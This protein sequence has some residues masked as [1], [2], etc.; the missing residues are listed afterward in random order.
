VTT[1]SA[2]ELIGSAAGSC[3][4]S[5]FT[6]ASGA[7]NGVKLAAANGQWACS[8]LTYNAGTTYADFDFSSFAPS[9]ATAPLSTGALTANA[10]VKII[11]RNVT[12]PATAGNYPLIHY[13]GTDPTAG[14][15]SLLTS[16][17]TVTNAVGGGV[18]V[19]STGKNVSVS[20]AL[21]V[22]N[23]AFTIAPHISQRITLSDIQAA[24]LSSSNG[25]P[26]YSITG[27]S[28]TSAQ[29]GAVIYNASNVQYTYPSSGS[30]AS[31]SFSYTVTDGTVSATGTVSLTFVKQAGQSGT[32]SVSGGTAT[33]T[34][35]GIPGVQY[36]AQRSSDLMNWMTL[37]VPPLN[38]TP[39]FAAASDGKVSFTDTNAPG[40]SAYY[41]TIQH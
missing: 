23:L 19:D 5:A 33:V 16:L 2:G 37:G 20:V 6:V 39:P 7:T 28:S 17:P 21:G 14:N 32:I 35:Y 30:P 4:S 12:Y 8:G 40:T 27:A 1:V 26:S 38:A 34:L 9:S 36:D 3:A 41:R 15:F 13:T 24:G 31:D 29:G 22:P 10:T 18:V 11:L 25:S